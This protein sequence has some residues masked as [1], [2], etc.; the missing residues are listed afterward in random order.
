MYI[1]KNRQIET[2]IYSDVYGYRISHD[3]CKGLANGPVKQEDQR[4]LRNGSTSHR[5]QYIF[6]Q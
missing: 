2:Y 4:P 3:F 5:P 1:R 6:S